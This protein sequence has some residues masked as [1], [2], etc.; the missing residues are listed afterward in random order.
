MFFTRD[1]KHKLQ[2]DTYIQRARMFGSRG[3]YLKYFEL[4]IPESLYLDWQKCFI[5][6]R[7]SLESRKQNKT[8]PIWLDG[9]RIT[10]VASASIDKTNVD[11]DKGEMSFDLFV[12]NEEQI[13]EV[14]GMSIP[15][16]Q[17]IRALSELLGKNCLPDYLI[18]Y[19]DSFCPVGDDSIA[20]HSPKSIAGYS[21]KEGEV[22][23]A[24]IT[25]T[26]GFIG[27]FERETDKYPNA[28]HHINI[29]FNEQGKA[30]VFYKY[31]GSIRFLKTGRK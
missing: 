8:S 9:Q 15:P 6:H 22:D 23:K 19:I 27:K 1:V 3:S 5:F 16:L 12:Y 13:L 21:D 11:V 7:L 26:K 28:I 20:V 10:A 29:L 18:N 25:R 14:L 4:I 30:R 24:T 17:K 31:Q 2:Q